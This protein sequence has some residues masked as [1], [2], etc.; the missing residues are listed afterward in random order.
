M[1]VLARKVKD[2]FRINLSRDIV[3]NPELNIFALTNHA[4]KR[5]DTTL[6]KWLPKIKGNYIEIKLITDNSQGPLYFFDAVI[7][8][9]ENIR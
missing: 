2:S 1:E 8:I 5:T 9:K 6:T 3:V 7:E 4:Q